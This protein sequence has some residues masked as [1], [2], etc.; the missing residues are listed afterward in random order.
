MK[1]VFLLLLT[2][3]ALSAFAEGEP[4]KVCHEKQKNG[5]TVQECK[6]VKVHKK[7]EGE[8]VPD[9]PAKKKK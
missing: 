6:V 4:K 1:K 2:M 3:F 8:A 9:A 5:K 7:L